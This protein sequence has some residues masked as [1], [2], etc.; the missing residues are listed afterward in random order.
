MDKQKALKLLSVKGFVSYY[1]SLM[2]DEQITQM[3]AYELTELEFRKH[4]G[5]RRY[6]SFDS[7]RQVRNRVIRKKS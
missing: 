4:F 7:F 3:K 1:F 5:R 2:R 6:S